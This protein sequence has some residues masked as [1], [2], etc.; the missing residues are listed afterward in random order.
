[1][2]TWLPDPS[3]YPEQMTPLSATVWFEAMGKGLHEATRRLRAPFGGFATRTE[4]GWAYEAQLDPEWEP[5]PET[6]RAAALGLPDRWREDLVPRVRAITAELERFRPERPAPNEARA[7]FD[8]L[9]ELVQEQWLLHFLVVIPAQAAA[10]LFREAFVELYGDDDPVA[11]YRL[12]ERGR[13]SA[14]EELY[15]LAQLARDLDVA[16]VISEHGVA[17][18]RVRLA[19]LAAGRRWLHELDAYL[20]RYGGRS[21]WHELSLPRESELPML[22]FEALRLALA[23]PATAPPERPA[24]ADVPE[25]LRDLA[26][27]V[28]DAHALKE[29]HS[30]E[31][32]YPG[33]Q[34]T[35]EVLRGYGRRLAAEGAF[36]HADDIWMLE[37]EEVRNALVGSLESLQSLVDRRRDELERGRAIGPEAF[38]GDPPAPGERHAIL[39]SFYGRRGSGFAG[40]PASRGSAEGIARIVR[41]P[42]DFARIES[43]EV[44]V[45][46]TTTPAW[47]PLFPSLAALVTETGGILSHAA[48]VAREYRLPAVVGVPDATHLIPD[49][50][51]VRVDGDEGT[52]ALL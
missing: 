21:R 25:E 32:D 23:R 28:R 45:T 9:W 52:V 12:L 11:P 24:V 17:D 6:F 33:L 22:T 20:L 46:T 2:T 42:G 38:L 3:H 37:R 15:A 35:R 18:A 4:L 36:A 34:A 49:G 40:T 10:D 13:N 8:R 47:T 14:D 44:L 7:S 1:M 27:R 50:S 16:D 29:L 26:E 41:D 5:D 48:V 30:Y 51:R 31:I 39:E 19:Q 43:G